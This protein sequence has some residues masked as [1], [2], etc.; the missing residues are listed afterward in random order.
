MACW[1]LV[2]CWKIR[3]AAV[4]RAGRRQCDTLLAPTKASKDKQNWPAKPA[5]VLNNIAQ[6]NN[7][8]SKIQDKLS[9]FEECISQSICNFRL[10]VILKIF[11]V[12]H[13]ADAEPCSERVLLQKHKYGF[14]LKLL[15][16]ALHLFDPMEIVTLSNTNNDFFSTYPCQS[17]GQWVSD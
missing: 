2:A 11:L 8:W 7:I 16:F 13:F 6:L 4:V 15:T 17:V 12:T 10:R 5:K 9:N 3:R 1:P 14:N